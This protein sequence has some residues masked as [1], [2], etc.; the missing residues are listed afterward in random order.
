VQSIIV[1][2]DEDVCWGDAIGAAMGF[3]R[4]VRPRGAPLAV[5][6]PVTSVEQTATMTKASGASEA[7][8]MKMGSF[9][10]RGS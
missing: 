5:S 7:F 6:D 9:Q 8:L 10:G 4:A 3:R 1:E 2:E